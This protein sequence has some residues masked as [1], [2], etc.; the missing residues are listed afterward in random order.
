MTVSKLPPFLFLFA[1]LFFFRNRSANIRYDGLITSLV[2][3]P[4]VIN[5]VAPFQAHRLRPNLPVFLSPQLLLI[6]DDSVK[7]NCVSLQ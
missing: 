7:P 3:L 2:H 1:L 6:H 4:Q 5:C